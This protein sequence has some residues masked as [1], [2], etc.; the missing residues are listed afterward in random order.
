MCFIYKRAARSVSSWRLNPCS[1]ERGLGVPRGGGLC[2]TFSPGWGSLV[3][4]APGSVLH[5]HRGQ[6]CFY[7]SS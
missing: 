6:G 3:F 1:G 7:F 4:P 2:P 5:G